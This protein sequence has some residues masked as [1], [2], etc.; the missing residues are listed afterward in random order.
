MMI[1]TQTW[2]ITQ[3]RHSTSE[4]QQYMDEPGHVIILTRR[5][6]SDLAIMSVM[7]YLELTEHCTDTKVQQNRQELLELLSRKEG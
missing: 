7:T 6:K 5:G 1:E 4:A 2:S 3:Y